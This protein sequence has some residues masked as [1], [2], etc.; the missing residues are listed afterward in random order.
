MTPHLDTD[1]QQHPIGPII[2]RLTSVTPAQHAVDLV[3]L[4]GQP[5]V[6]AEHRARDA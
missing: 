3:E 6:G 2:R 1:K 4:G 5:A